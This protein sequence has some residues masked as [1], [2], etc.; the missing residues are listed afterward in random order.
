MRRRQLRSLSKI[1]LF[2]V[3]MARPATR[4]DEPDTAA[5]RAVAG[6]DRAYAKLA[7]E[8]GMP[9]ASI[10]YFA[11]DGVAFA[12]RVRNGRKYWNS[13]LKDFAGELIWQPVF[14]AASRGGDL[15][16]TTGP[17]ELKR[18]G[19]STGFGHYLSIWS[20]QSDGSWK[21]E[22]DIGIDHSQPT[23]PF[24]DLQLQAPD[25]T[26]G[27]RPLETVKKSLADARRRFAE[28]EK[29]DSSAALLTNAA[30]E[31]R[32]YRD[33]ALPALGA[34]AARIMLSSDHGR[35]TRTE[36]G[37]KLSS[38]ADLFFTYGGYKEEKGNTIE[39]GVYVSIWRI[40]LNGDWQMMVDL[41]KR[42]PRL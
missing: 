35:Q 18:D 6:A 15:A 26:A 22:L 30:E 23:D 4:A 17:W 41:Q 27:E 29:K 31:I 39:K 28:V 8:K 12:P 42:D 36:V 1:V 24:S 37:G 9:T 11:A 32:V 7:S 38:S 10:E 40:N 25:A 13:R 20:R 19:K 5:A 2:S 33:N 16:Y 34:T 3:L 21:M 14:A